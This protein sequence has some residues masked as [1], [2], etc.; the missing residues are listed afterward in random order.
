ML[1]DFLYQGFNVDEAGSRVFDALMIH[2][3]GGSRGSCTQRFAASG[4][5]TYFYPSRFPFTAEEQTDPCN[6]TV[7]RSPV[8]I[9]R[10]SRSSHSTTRSSASA[11]AIARS[12]CTMALAGIVRNSNT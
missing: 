6:L 1:R 2:I 12:C 9:R 3:A 5:D 7:C 11:T 4:S 10:H 8:P